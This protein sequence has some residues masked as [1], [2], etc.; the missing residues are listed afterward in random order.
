MI[1][2]QTL[3]VVA[4]SSVDFAVNQAVEQ[5]GSLMVAGAEE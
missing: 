5:A 3:R 1:D 4:L 2:K